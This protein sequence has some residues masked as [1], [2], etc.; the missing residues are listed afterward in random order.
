ME[1]SRSTTFGLLLVFFTWRFQS[2]EVL[3]PRP[4]GSD[5]GAV[6]S[7]RSLL[8]PLQLNNNLLSSDNGKKLFLGL[9]SHT[10][11][12]VGRH[13]QRCLKINRLYFHIDHF[14]E[15]WCFTRRVLLLFPP[16]HER[17]QSLLIFMAPVKKIKW[18][19]PIN[20]LIYNHHFIC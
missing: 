12:F 8:F 14:T 6:T 10:L 11:L 7:R 19:N 5:W 13:T 15:V 1:I 17:K 3:L 4:P 16:W 18:I 2:V 9:H 20:S